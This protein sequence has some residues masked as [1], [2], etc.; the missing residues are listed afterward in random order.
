MQFGI[1]TRIFLVVHLNFIGNFGNFVQS[2]QPGKF[3]HRI[4]DPIQVYD[5][6]VILI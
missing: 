2:V 5:Q 1:L 6:E 3:S 4:A